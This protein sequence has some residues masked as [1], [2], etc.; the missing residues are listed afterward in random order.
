MPSAFISFLLDTCTFF[1]FTM[2]IPSPSAIRLAASGMAVASKV[3]TLPS[4]S[5]S[6][7]YRAASAASA[8]GGN[9]LATSAGTTTSTTTLAVGAAKHALDLVRVKT[10]LD[11]LHSYGVIA[12]LMM[13]ASLRLYSSTP[14]RTDDGGISFENVIKFLFTMSMML[15]VISGSYTTIVFALLGLYSKRALG[16]GMD[17]KFVKFFD[18]TH[19]IRESGFDAFVMCLATFKISFCLSLFLN[20]RGKF[21]W[22]ILAVASIL[23]CFA[24]YKWSTIMSLAN[25]IL[26]AGA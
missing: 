7:L 5:T 24:W 4:S 16:M 25:T 14:K 21:R 3:V 8:Y 6:T 11:G 2:L 12:A 19:D 15:S 10:R 26:F 9:F 22:V 20:Y 1:F 18:A 23:S 17:E 13:N